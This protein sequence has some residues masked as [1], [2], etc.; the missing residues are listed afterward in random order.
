MVEEVDREDWRMRQARLEEMFRQ[1][2]VVI[3]YL[4]MELI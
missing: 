3:R 4:P 1:D 2:K